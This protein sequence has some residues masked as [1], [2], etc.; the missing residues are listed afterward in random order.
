MKQWYGMRRVRYG[1]LARNACHLRF[2]VAAMNMKRA[3][4]LIEKARSIAPARPA[5]TTS[6]PDTQ[7]P[8][9]NNP[10]QFKPGA[11]QTNPRR[12]PTPNDRPTTG[13]TPNSEKLSVVGWRMPSKARTQLP[14]TERR[15]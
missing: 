4:V 10:H 8:R 3:L 7:S 2:V 13:Q 11:N 12:P 5:L 14:E 9:G 1:G 15:L 6:D